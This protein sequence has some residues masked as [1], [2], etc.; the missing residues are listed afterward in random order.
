MTGQF[1]HVVGRTPAS[2][3]DPRS[4]SAEWP[5]WASAADQGVRPGVRPT[6]YSSIP[7]KVFSMV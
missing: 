7:D 2:A 6:W 5:T 4:G 3:P 1:N